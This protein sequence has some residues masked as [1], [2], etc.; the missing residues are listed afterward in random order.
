MRVLVD[1][2]GRTAWPRTDAGEGG[3][4]NLVALQLAR[5]WRFTGPV[6][7][8]Q[9]VVTEVTV[10][11]IFAPGTNPVDVMYTDAAPISMT[12]Y[13]AGISSTSQNPISGGVYPSWPVNATIVVEVD[14][15]ATSIRTTTAEDQIDAREAG[16]ALAKWAFTPGMRNGI[17]VATRMHIAIE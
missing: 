6:K 16:T 10:K 15:H 11:I 1:E 9:P 4:L 17:L 8:G 13:N 14:G 12:R 5:S 3:M 2:E 7:A